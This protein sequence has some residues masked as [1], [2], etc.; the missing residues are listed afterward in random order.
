MFDVNKIS[1]LKIFR[2][3]KIN[4]LK[5]IIGGTLIGKKNTF[6]KACKLV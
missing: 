2:G 3:I 5:I 6:K 4:L 1:L